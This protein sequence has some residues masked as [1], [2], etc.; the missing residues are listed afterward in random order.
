[1]NK[2]STQK[3][4]E[5]FRQIPRLIFWMTQKASRW[6]GGNSASQVRTYQQGC[7]RRILQYCPAANMEGDSWKIAESGNA[8]N[9]G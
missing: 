1:V 8:L 4:S 3:I 6:C 7:G 2:Y 5:I 9:V